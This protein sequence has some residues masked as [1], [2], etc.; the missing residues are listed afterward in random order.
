MGCSTDFTGTIKFKDEATAGQLKFISQFM[1]EDCRQHPDWNCNGLTHIDLKICDDF[2]GIEWNGSEKTYDLKEKLELISRMTIDQYP[3][4]RFTG[5]LHAQGDEFDDRYVIRAKDD[6]TFER[7]DK[8]TPTEVNEILQLL[9]ERIE[10]N[11]ECCISDSD[12][13]Y[14]AIKGVLKTYG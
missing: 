10:S 3:H 6:G 13:L 7:L 4:F 14:K 1:G 9:V 12:S 8:A 5:E 2:G 11:G